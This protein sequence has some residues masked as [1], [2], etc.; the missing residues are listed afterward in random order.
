MGERRRTEGEEEGRVE[1]KEEHEGGK[2]KD[3]VWGRGER[4]E[5]EA[6]RGRRGGGESRTDSTLSTGLDLTIPRS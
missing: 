5:K 2:E 3:E 1:G 6:D 4:K